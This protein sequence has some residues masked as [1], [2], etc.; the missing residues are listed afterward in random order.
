M[1][2]HRTASTTWTGDL[3]SGSGEVNFRSSEAAGPLAVT[4]ASRVERADGRTS[5]EELLA[6]SQAACYAM[7]LS[8]TLAGKGHT[9][10]R[11][12]V[13]ATCT[14]EKPENAGLEVKSMA[15][16]VRAKV[17]GLDDETFRQIAKEA[18]QGCPIAA[19]IR[20]NVEITL[21]AALEG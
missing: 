11:L 8:H 7:A 13:D 16:K 10:E 15:I 5:P 14:A 9:P 18:E 21:D 2:A 1:Q 6:A 20:G 19:A 4:W 3:V 17:P 12:E